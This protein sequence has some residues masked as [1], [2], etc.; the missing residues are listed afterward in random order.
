MV[1]NDCIHSGG[2]FLLGKE[3]GIPSTP[4]K[5]DG[6]ELAPVLIQYISRHI[7][8]LSPDRRLRFPSNAQNKFLERWEHDWEDQHSKSAIQSPCGAI[9]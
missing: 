3:E 8:A 1:C 6:C 9:Q 5:P 4:A 7:E 2:R